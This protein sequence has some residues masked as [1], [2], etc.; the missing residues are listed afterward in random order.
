MLFDF[1]TTQYVAQGYFI[2]GATYK[3]KL[4]P[5]DQ[6]KYLIPLAFPFWGTSGAQPWTQPCIAGIA[7]GTAPGTRLFKSPKPTRRER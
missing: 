3:S 1:P 6:K 7:K 2:V 5:G 4:M